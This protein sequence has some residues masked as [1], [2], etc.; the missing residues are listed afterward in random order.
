MVKQKRQ[1]IVEKI[2]TFSH[3]V[4]INLIVSYYQ[5][6]KDDFLFFHGHGFLKDAGNE[7]IVASIVQSN[8]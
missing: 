1:N 4:F 6:D 3:V 2:Q 8:P 5:E 7:K